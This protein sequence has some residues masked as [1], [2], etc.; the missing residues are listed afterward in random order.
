MYRIEHIGIAVKSLEAG[1]RLY[2]RLLNVAPYKEELVEEQGVITSFFRAGEGKVELL[3]ATG[4]H[5][6][7]H[8]FI[9]RKGEGI[10][11]IAFE[12]SDIRAEMQRLSELGFQLIQK[13]PV[14]GADNKLVC[15]IHPKSSQ[16]VLV[17]ICQSIP[18]ADT[19]AM[20]D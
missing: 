7:I 10:H 18:A 15:F 12:V 3:Q 17:E 13:E 6:P 4:E 2:E 19:D 9:E 11:H 1:N 16:G 14:R 5:S 20:D 8:Q